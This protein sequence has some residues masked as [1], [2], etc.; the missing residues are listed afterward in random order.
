[1][2]NAQGQLELFSQFADLPYQNLVGRPPKLR[3]RLLVLLRSKGPASAVD[4]AKI[5][6]RRPSRILVRLR[7]LVEDGHIR[8]DGELYHAAA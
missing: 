8:K 1:M 4:L 6:H 7:R 5:I 3:L 2:K